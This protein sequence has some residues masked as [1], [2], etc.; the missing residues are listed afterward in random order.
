M[1][2]TTSW[3][4]VWEEIFQRQ[5]WGK[6]PPEHVIR[7]VARRFYKAPDRSAVRLLDLGCGPGACTWFMAREGFA[8]SGIDGSPSGLRKAAEYL[9]REGV[10]ADLRTGDFVKLP[11]P[12][13]YFDAVIDNA[14]LYSNRYADCQLV[15][16]EV[17]R[18]LKPGGHFQSAN[19]SDRTWGYGLGE[20][21]EEN[22]FINIPEGPLQ[23][24]GFSLFFGQA[25]ID[26]LYRRFTDV[27]VEKA[28]W[29]A[30]S[31]QK[32]VELWIVEA[33]KP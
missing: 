12:D 33:R 29:T 21:V 18:V 27:S 28:S 13:D 3:D 31:L 26:A 16:D 25:Q 14:S 30:D 4:P 15:C 11:W 6:Y 20:Q 19:F 5:D 24:R 22:G 8:V 9:S 17:F 10:S 1:N 32:L 2:T 23:A 7:F